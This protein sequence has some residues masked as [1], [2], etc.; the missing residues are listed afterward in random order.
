MVDTNVVVAGIS[1]FRDRYIPGRF[2]VP[3]CSAVG[4]EEHFVRLYSEETLTEYKEVLKRLQFA[5]PRSER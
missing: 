1:G 2:R 3:I 4:G 5:P